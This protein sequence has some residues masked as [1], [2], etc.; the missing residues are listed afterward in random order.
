MKEVTNAGG[1]GAVQCPLQVMI[2]TVTKKWFL[3]VLNQ[4]GNR[5][6]IRYNELFNELSGISPKSL[7]DTLKDLQQ[8]NLVKREIKEGAPP[9]VEYSLTKEG[10]TLRESVVP[11]LKW[12]A[13]YTH[14]LSCPILGNMA[15]DRQTNDGT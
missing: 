11:L 14:H 13:G 4:I 3:L 5:G 1:K 9:K 2:S 15:E 7:S 10:A 6:K 12:A 8:M